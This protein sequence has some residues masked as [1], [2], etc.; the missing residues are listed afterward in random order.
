MIFSEFT[1]TNLFLVCRVVWSN[2]FCENQ[3]SEILLCPFGNN[4]DVDHGLRTKGSYI[5]DVPQ[6][7]GG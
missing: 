6:Q 5:N 3:N 2:V 4:V 1:C 7:G